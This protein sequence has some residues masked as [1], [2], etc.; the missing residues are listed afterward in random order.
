[1]NCKDYRR[2]LYKCKLCSCSQYA[3]TDGVLLGGD[4]VRR[5]LFAQ[6]FPFLKAKAIKNLLLDLPSGTAEDDDFLHA[7]SAGNR[8][9]KHTFNWHVLQV[10]VFE[11]VNISL[12][13]LTAQVGFFFFFLGSQSP[14]FSCFSITAFSASSSHPVVSIDAEQVSQTTTFRLLWSDFGQS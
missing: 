12:Q 3:L 5:P 4:V 9:F 2:G 8:C 10:H 14:D 11:K 6:S 1:M 13:R 7:W